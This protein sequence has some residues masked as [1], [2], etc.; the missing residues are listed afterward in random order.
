MDEG[1]RNKKEKHM[2]GLVVK[3]EGVIRGNE[4]HLEQIRS[5]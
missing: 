2:R 5:E 3:S 1:C 4:E